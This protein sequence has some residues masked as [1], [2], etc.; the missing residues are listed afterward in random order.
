MKKN[1]DS[2]IIIALSITAFV[3]YVMYQK[4]KHKKFVSSNTLTIENFVNRLSE[5]DMSPQKEASNFFYDLLECGFSPQ[6]AFA[7][8]QKEIDDAGSFFK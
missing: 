1:G 3:G 6:N 7:T 2:V 8:V 5:Y 4:S